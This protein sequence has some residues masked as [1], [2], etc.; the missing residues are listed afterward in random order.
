MSETS[1]PKVAGRV[2][3]PLP[4]IAESVA[5]TCGNVNN[6]IDHLLCNGLTIKG[7]LLGL[8]VDLHLQIK[9]DSM[10]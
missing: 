8:P 9:N 7:K 3:R 4:E 10:K 1:A 6:L 2:G 5:E